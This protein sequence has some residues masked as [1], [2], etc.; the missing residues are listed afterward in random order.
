VSAPRSQ[1]VS[2]PDPRTLANRGDVCRSP[3]EVAQ[4][5]NNIHL[6]CALL[7]QEL[8]GQKAIHKVHRVERLSGGNERK[9]RTKY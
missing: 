2:D 5:L 6:L 9:A 3:L 4:R 8:L 1:P 7:M